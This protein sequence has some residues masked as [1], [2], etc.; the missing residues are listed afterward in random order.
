MHQC[1]HH[2]H[3][4]DSYGRAFA[5][6]VILNVVFVVVEAAFGLWFNSLAL[7]AEYKSPLVATLL[8]TPRT[9]PDVDELFQL[10]PALHGLLAPDLPPATLVKL[11]IASV[12]GASPARVFAEP[13]GLLYDDVPENPP[14]M[15]DKTMRVA[16]DAPCFVSQRIANEPMPLAYTA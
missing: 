15:L 8:M 16:G 3:S 10:L 5:I 13:E 7:L 9:D 14:I 4:T 12:T 2:N 1:A 11:A 6:G